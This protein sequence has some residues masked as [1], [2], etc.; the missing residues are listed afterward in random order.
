M[1]SF[2][3]A[4]QAVFPI[5]IMIVIGICLRQFHIIQE[6]SFKEF[7][8]IVFHMTLPI[9]IFMNIVQSDLKEIADIGLLAYAY[10]FIILTILISNFL[11]SY[12]NFDHN[13]KPVIVQC[14]YR[15]NFIIFGLPIVQNLYGEQNTGLVS[16]LIAWVIPLFNFAAVILLESY[17]EIHHSKLETLLKILKNPLIIASALAIL[18]SLLNISIPK[19]LLEPLSLINKMGTPLSLIVLG[20]LF[21]F[22]SLQKNRKPLLIS[23]LGRLIIVPTICMVIAILLGYRDIALVSLLVMAGG[24]IAISSYSMVLYMGF[25][26]DLS[27]QQMVA[28]TLFVLPTLVFFLTILG[29]LQLI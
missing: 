23:V 2:F 17:R 9:S 24:P 13:Q 21:S 19:I 16:L 8:W 14:I 20:G 1:N 11:I 27:A 10:I 15:S 29:W 18:V 22:E 26:A 28:T 12:S 7:N 6:S 5:T 3:I 25:D 4:F